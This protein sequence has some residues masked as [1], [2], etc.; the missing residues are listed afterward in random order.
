MDI[1]KIFLLFMFY[2]FFGWLMEVTWVFIRT[3][4]VVNRGFLIGPY[5]PIYGV[6]GVII[7]LTLTKY[8][9]SPI[10]LFI[11]AMTI[12]AI[13]EYITS[14]LMEKFFNARWW[15]YTNYKYNINGRICLET[16]VTFGL[17]GLLVVYILYPFSNYIISIMGNN[18]RIALSIILFLIFFTDV[19]VSLKIISNFKFTA[20]Q[21][22]NKDNTEEIT[23]KVRETL[24]NKSVFNK[25]LVDA[26]PNF[27]SVIVNIKNELVK[28]K[29]ELKFTKRKLKHTDKE[30]K[31]LK[32]K[33]QKSNKK[34]N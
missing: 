12:C 34:Q 21:F 20:I 22:R 27:K 11:M 15:D 5:C 14:Y 26:F 17:C 7:T 23:K 32:K 19:F 9:G 24:S 25:R 6:G 28:T 8:Y 30:L 16:M 18:F 31:K 33:V 2:S 13:L 29:Q 3:K 1:Y 4:K 10:T